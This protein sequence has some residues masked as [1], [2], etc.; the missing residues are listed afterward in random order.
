MHLLLCMFF[1]MEVE[2]RSYER[3]IDDRKNRKI[4]IGNE[5]KH[6]REQQNSSNRSRLESERQRNE[7]NILKSKKKLDDFEN[8]NEEGVEKKRLDELNE[9]KNDLTFEIKELRNKCEDYERNASALASIEQKK[10]IVNNEMTILTNIQNDIEADLR[11]LFDSDNESD[12]EHLCERIENH[13]Q[14]KEEL[15]K[16][17]QKRVL[18]PQLLS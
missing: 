6:E 5:I 17:A 10:D 15:Y 4:A 12:L 8:N 1:R 11:A 18:D 13:L 3:Q 14:L 9:R 2:N 7:N 16:V